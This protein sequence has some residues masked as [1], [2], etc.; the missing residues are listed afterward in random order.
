MLLESCLLFYFVSFFISS[1]EYSTSCVQICRLKQKTTHGPNK[2]FNKSEVIRYIYIYE[3]N[4]IKQEWKQSSRKKVEEIIRLQSSANYFS[5]F[6]LIFLFFF[7]WITKSC[8]RKKKFL[9]LLSIVKTWPK[10]FS[11]TVPINH[12]FYIR[13]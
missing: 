1:A 3:A 4:V 11:A 6:L 13:K 7:K 2:L 8:E 5:F 10:I 12:N 9:Y